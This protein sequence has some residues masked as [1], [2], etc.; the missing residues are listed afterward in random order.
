MKQH[1]GY[2]SYDDLAAH[3][4]EWVE[5]VSIDYRGYRLWE[6]PPNGQGIAALQI[7]AI[8]KGST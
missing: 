5:P 2:L 4:S 8:L 3:Q 6:L 1:G 7:L